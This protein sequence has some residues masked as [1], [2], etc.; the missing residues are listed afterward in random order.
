M[1]P[2]QVAE[3]STD[4]RFSIIVPAYGVEAYLRD[5]LDSVLSQSF[6]DFEVIAVNDA[7][8]D[9]CGEIMD[10]YAAADRRVVTVQLEQ[11]VGL[12]QARNVG[13][14]RARGAY[15]IFL[16]S[17]DTLLPGSLRAIARRLDEND[18]PDLLVFDYSRTY[19]DGRITPNAKRSVLT[20]SPRG[21]FRLDDNPELLG[22]LQVA[23]NKAYRRDF[24]ERWGFVYPTGYY[25]DTPWTYPVLVAAETIAVLDR[26]CVHY[27]QRRQGSILS[28]ASRKHFDVFDQYDL[29]M[30]F[31]AAHPEFERW[32]G[33]LFER[34]A[35]H[36]GVIE[37]MPGR[38]PAG[39]RAEFRARRLEAERTHRPAGYRD[40]KT[41]PKKSGVR[42]AANRLP[43]RLRRPAR[44]AYRAAAKLK[45]PVRTAVLMA[46]YRAQRMLP[47]KKDTAVFAAYWNA[48]YACNPAAI[49][50]KLRELAPHVKPT[51]VLK[52]DP[53]NRPPAD[54]AT[55][56]PGSFGFWRAMARSKYFVNNVNFPTRVVK[57]PGQVFVQ[58]HHG[59]PLKRMGVDQVEFPLGAAQM[60]M[61]LLM[62]RVDHWDY[63]ISSNSFTTATWDRAYPSTSYSSLDYGY[64]RNDVLVNAT[65]ADRTAAREKLGLAPDAKVVLYAPT[66]RDYQSVPQPLLD[67]E[68]FADSLG[69]GFTVLVRAHYFNLGTRH[70]TTDGIID[71]SGHPSVEELYLAADC[72]LTDYSSLMFDYALL[73]RPVVI[74]AN[75]WEVYRATR[76]TY[77]DIHVE[78]P[79]PVVATKEDLIDVFLSGRWSDDT[80]AKVRTEFRR[81]F[82][83]YDDG[84]AAER[85]VRRVFLDQ[86]DIPPVALPPERPVRPVRG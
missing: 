78:S 84:R 62:H 12:G 45:K 39:A 10:E 19:W 55:V 50:Q 33:P 75:D 14:T 32:R 79:G 31:L 67:V 9:A 21:T 54:T 27:R 61:E 63:S 22:L 34:M 24:I 66:H 68:H 74:Y 65:D 1:T 52:P 13:L 64:P 81:R 40:P 82:C 59:T 58:T 44:K 47:V 42:R 85:V 46:Y 8:P 17:D 72:L 38:L 15:L 51:W 2:T 57:R 73:D 11:N 36:L 49:D 4:P 41:K 35:F 70:G 25:E 5:C 3:T 76:G 26:I 56:H 20:Q 16:D 48:D 7:S 43:N 23:W 80:S 53:R 18:D 30:S 69:D 77:F 28:S 86:E 60:D 29:V 6:E 37:R 83:E 71:V